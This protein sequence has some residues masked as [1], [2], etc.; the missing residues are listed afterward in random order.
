MMHN[1]KCE[2][3]ICYLILQWSDRCLQLL[4]RRDFITCSCI[5]WQRL[6]ISDSS[7]KRNRV[8]RILPRKN[9]F[10]I[11]HRIDQPLIKCRNLY[12]RFTLIF[13]IQ[14]SIFDTEFAL[15]S[16]AREAGEINKSLLTLGRVI[17]ALVEH[18]G[19]VPYR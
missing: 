4:Q 9:I 1:N 17:N 14:R 15:Q 13:Q 18:S 6:L 5:G 12:K 2:L 10:S 19:H 16:R 3:Y 7:L 11:V 8:R